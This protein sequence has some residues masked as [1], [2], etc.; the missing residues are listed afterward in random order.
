[1]ATFSG[2]AF[3][4]TYVDLLQINNSNSGI[5][6]S[7]LQMQDGAGVGLPIRMSRDVINLQPTNGNSTTAF[8]VSNLAGNSV[9]VVDST[10]RATYVYQNSSSAEYVN[11][12]FAYFSG[13]AIN[14]DGSSHHCIPFGNAPTTSMTLGTGTDPD[15]SLTI[16]TTADDV[17]N[18][19]W[20][21]LDNGIVI[22]SVF[23]YVA[24]DGASGDT[25][26]FHLM[27]YDINVEDSSSGG[28]LSGGVV[29]ASGSDISHDGYEQMDVQ[30]MTIDSSNKAVGTYGKALFATIKAD[31]TN[32]NY[33]IKMM[34]KFHWGA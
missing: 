9:L 4:D 23:V 11:T 15:T 20:F 16:A 14:V 18:C 8:K 27:E 31:G 6:A 17:V 22:D 12:G 7:V 34:V 10:N 26:R 19:G 5:G 24:G 21:G 29:V 30:D 25:I 13:T 1:M 28:D 3:K 2:A 32:S 33:S